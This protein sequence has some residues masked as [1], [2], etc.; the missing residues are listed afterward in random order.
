MQFKSKSQWE[1]KKK[2]PVRVYYWNLTDCKIS[3]KICAWKKLGHLKKEWKS[4]ALPDIMNSK[5]NNV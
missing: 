4:L 2:I 1:R 3:S 5:G